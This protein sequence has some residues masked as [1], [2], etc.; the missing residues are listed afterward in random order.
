MAS[1]HTVL[2][3][4]SGV[5][6]VRGEVR[7]WLEN[8]ESDWLFTPRQVELVSPTGDRRRVT[9][10]ARPGAG[11]R[12]L[13]RIEGVQDRDEAR[14]LMEWQIEVATADLPDPGPGAWYLAHL[15]G[16]AV[17]T[18]SGRSLGRLVAVHRNTPV[19]LWEARGPEG[20]AYVPALEHNLIEVSPETVRVR[21]EA[22]VWDEPEPSS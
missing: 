5:F 4:I 7:L 19:H 11:R 9:L 16:A 15:L 12:I 20:R 21:D 14:S 8:P 1:S 13:G 22:V 6:G 2:G 18:G 17:V 10:T 3:R